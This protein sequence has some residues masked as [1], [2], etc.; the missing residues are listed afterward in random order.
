[1]TR[2]RR[3]FL[4]D[5]C[6]G[7]LG[8]A[9][10]ATQMHHFG[11]ISTYAQKAIDDGDLGEGGANYKALVMLYFDGGNDSN[12]MIIPVHNDSQVSNY[13]AYVAARGQ[14]PFGGNPGSSFELGFTQAQLQNTNFNVP[15]L[16][17]LTYAMHPAL[18]PAATGAINP[19]IYELYAQGKLAIVSNVGTLVRPLSKGATYNSTPKPYQIGSHS[20]QKTQFQTSVSNTQSFTGWGGRISDR[21]TSVHN[22]NGLVPMIT[23]ISGAQLFT[24]GQTTL[25]MAIGDSNTPLNSVLNPV[26]FGTTPT[27][28][29]LSRR[30]AFDALR[31][32]DLN[33]NYIAAASHV[34]DLAM[35]ANA[36]LQVTQDVTV[37]FPNTGVGRQLRQVARLVKERNDLNINR[38]IFYVQI[39]GFDTH[40]GELNGH[41]NLYSQVGQ[42]MRAFYDEMVVQGVSN[43]VTLFTMSEFGRTLNPAGAGTNVGTDHGWGS[44]LMVLGGSVVGGNLYGS[45]RPDGTG[46]YFPTLLMGNNPLALDDADTGA[47]GRGRWIPTTSVDQYAAQLARWFGLPQDSATLNAVFPNLQFFPGTHSQLGF[48][49]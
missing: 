20:D 33:A 17:N 37:P 2:S 24:A 29:N 18:G 4:K 36:A 39:G 21:L 30:T 14:Q 16:G 43:D 11:T 12:N 23:S 34:T 32:Q 3:E 1:M 45:K 19:G 35:T 8:M 48:L 46:D 38:Q 40:T 22:P 10:M 44:H 49:P 26:G 15:R 5:S 42:A 47:T 41:T 27:G 25:P 6:C 13:A 28:A 9:A 7:A 31:Q